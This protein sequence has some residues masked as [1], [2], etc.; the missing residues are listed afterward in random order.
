MAIEMCV[1]CRYIEQQLVAASQ[2]PTWT[3][4]AFH[5]YYAHGNPATAAGKY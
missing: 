3:N 1:P 5:K 4:I 2:M